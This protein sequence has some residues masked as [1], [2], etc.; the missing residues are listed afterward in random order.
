MSA[1]LNFA[2]VTEVF[3]LIFFSFVNTGI[4]TER[5][6]VGNLKRDRIV[7]RNTT[8]LS[9]SGNVNMLVQWQEWEGRVGVRT[10][11]LE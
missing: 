5:S 4:L 7:V 3:L 8:I 10:L 1:H 6:M 9:L 2:A 11:V